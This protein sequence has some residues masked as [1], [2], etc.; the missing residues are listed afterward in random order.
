MATYQT[1]KNKAELKRQCKAIEL[2]NRAQV[3]KSKNE[4]PVSGPNTS[5]MNNTPSTTGCCLD[6]FR[7]PKL[8]Q[9]KLVASNEIAPVMQTQPIFSPENSCQLM[10]NNI[11]PRSTGHSTQTNAFKEWCQKFKE[12]SE[13]YHYALLKY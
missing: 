8:S 5:D 3:H 13:Q 11:S 4:N 12:A 6:G 9:A 10:D 2:A 1:D 7:I